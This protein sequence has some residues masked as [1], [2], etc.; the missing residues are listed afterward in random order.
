MA[1]MFQFSLRQLAAA[2]LWVAVLFALSRLWPWPPEFVI[3]AIGAVF[4]FA[5]G[6]VRTRR[7]PVVGAVLGAILI[8]PIITASTWIL[9]VLAGA[10]PPE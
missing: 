3:P 10:W 8:W 6:L 5:F 2:V 1:G 7:A 9:A 4:G